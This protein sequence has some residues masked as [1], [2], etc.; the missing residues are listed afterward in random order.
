MQDYQFFTL[1][2]MLAAGFGWLIYQMGDLKTRVTVIETI[3]S[4]AGMPIKPGKGKR[5]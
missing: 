2:G 5:E 4:I 3:L 1:I